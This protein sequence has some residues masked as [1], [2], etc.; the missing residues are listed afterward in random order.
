[1]ACISGATSSRTRSWGKTACRIWIWMDPN[2]IT[3]HPP[4][5]MLGHHN[6]CVEGLVTYLQNVQVLEFT[7]YPESL[8]RLHL[9]SIERA[10]SW[11]PF[12]LTQLKVK[13]L[14]SERRKAI[15]LYCPVCLFLRWGRGM[16]HPGATPLKHSNDQQGKI[17]LNVQCVALICWW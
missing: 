4:I 2:Q 12:M 17:S 9:S 13:A 5:L 14:P 7:H 3:T 10:L 8:R 11:I 15:S 6:T 16:L 1:M